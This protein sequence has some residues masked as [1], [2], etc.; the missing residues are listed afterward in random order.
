MSEHRY[1]RRWETDSPELCLYIEQVSPDA[2]PELVYRD[3]TRC[4]Y[5]DDIYYLQQ[6]RDELP[7][8]FVPEPFD[9]VDTE[10]PV[11]QLARRSR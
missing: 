2:W 3:G 4:R 7:S 10:I 11:R 5:G 9:V 8:D 6:C 1:P